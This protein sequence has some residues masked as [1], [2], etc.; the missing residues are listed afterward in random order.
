MVS[1]LILEKHQRVIDAINTIYNLDTF[2]YQ[3]TQTTR[4]PDGKVEVSWSFNSDESKK[5]WYGHL[6]N[7]I[8]NIANMKDYIKKELVRIW[9]SNSLYEEYI[10]NVPELQ[11]VTDLS[12]LDKH[13]E[14]LRP[15]S[16][17]NPR[18]WN[19]LVSMSTDRLNRNKEIKYGNWY[20]TSNMSLRIDADIFDGA[21]NVIMTSDDLISWCMIHLRLFILENLDV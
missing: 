10:N 8:Q 11:I 14:T 20:M 21:W 9:K 4:R 3:S 12:N 1:D 7:I 18:L 6:M 19:V 17:L 13:S 16:T 2:E 15:R 5:K